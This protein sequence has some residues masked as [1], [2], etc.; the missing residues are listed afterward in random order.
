MS[1]IR[2][3]LLFQKSGNIQD[4]LIKNIIALLNGLIQNR[5]Q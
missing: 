4:I 5:L 1:Y 3:I 2:W